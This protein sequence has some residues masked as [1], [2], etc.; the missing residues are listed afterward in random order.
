[1]ISFEAT[2]SRRSGRSERRP[3]RGRGS[4][5]S[6]ETASRRVV[7]NPIKKENRIRATNGGKCRLEGFGDDVEVLAVEERGGARSDLCVAVPRAYT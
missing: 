5:P 3:L 2:A 1:M 7:G 6:D 4:A